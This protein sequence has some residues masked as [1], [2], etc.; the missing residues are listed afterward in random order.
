MG[1]IKAITGA[2]GG[3]LADQWKEFIYCDSLDADTLVIKGQKRT[4]GR[5]SNTKG[6]DNI[7]TN[8]SVIAINEGQAMVI[9]DQGKVVEFCAEPG[10][11][12]YD[13]STE[14]S[15]FTGD[16]GKG[17][18]DS[19]KRVGARFTFG[20][21]TGHDQR[22]YFFNI[23]EIVDNKYGTPTPVP[24]RVIDRN[25]GL[26][27]D[28]SVRCNGVY[29]YKIVDPV[30]FYTELCGN[31]TDRYLRSEIEGQMKSELL[32]ALQPAFARIS[33]AG[34]RYSEIPA[35]TTEVC[36]ALDEELSGKW[37]QLR[38]IKIKSFGVNS[39]AASEE[40]QQMIKDLQKSATM[41]DP[42]MAAAVLTGAQADAMRT[43]AANESGA[44][45]GFMGMGMV[46]GIAGN[47]AANMFAMGEQPVAA[48][49]APA[50]A[51]A[52]GAPVAAAAA[53]AGGWTCAC[54]NVNT[55]KFCHE[56]GAPKPEPQGWT[57][58]CGTVC[59]GKFC[60]ECGTPKPA[61]V[62]QYKCDKCGWEPEDPTKPP[63]FCPECGDPFG[64]EDI[65]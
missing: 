56:C 51:P 20:A 65:K 63:K 16:L 39:I 23:K 54:G 49:A 26:D 6:S 19:F 10:E 4:G 2:A 38:G 18:I 9:V 34:V 14:P 17:I 30:L 11:F 15:I 22:V 41:R 1:L 42:R 55:G 24:F 45:A 62:P 35:H 53:V 7:I 60:P 5:S 46:N 57:C 8:G 28:I 3:V 12:V 48:P 36:D 37:T 27:V 29:S 58:S 50:A 40:D 21:D 33:A 52:A 43:A 64:D 13:T 44:M 25:I 47:Q 61:G 59:Q 31:V 32:T